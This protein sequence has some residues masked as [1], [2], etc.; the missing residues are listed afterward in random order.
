MLGIQGGAM[1]SAHFGK[2]I[3]CEDVRRERWGYGVIMCV[4]C[5]A[6]G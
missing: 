4:V 1:A 3:V 5:S 2:G 6:Y